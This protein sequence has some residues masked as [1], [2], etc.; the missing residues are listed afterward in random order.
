MA[1]TRK[2]ESSSARAAASEQAL[3]DAGGKRANYRHPKEIVVALATIQRLTGDDATTI[4]NRL[5]LEERDRLQVPP[6]GRAR[7]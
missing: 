5:I 6:K 4:V 7:S 2:H 1:P 3:K